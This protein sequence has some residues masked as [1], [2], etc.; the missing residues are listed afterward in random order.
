M[1]ASAPIIISLSGFSQENLFQEIVVSPCASF[2]PG[3]TTQR[4][5][6][7]VEKK[8]ADYHILSVNP[9]GSYLFLQKPFFHTIFCYLSY[10]K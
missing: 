8:F 5:I 10:R 3:G 7:T 4:R 9:I 1:G 6:K 2:I